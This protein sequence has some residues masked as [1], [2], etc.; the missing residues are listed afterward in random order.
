MLINDDKF[1]SVTSMNINEKVLG[2]RFNR[3]RFFVNILAL[4]HILCEIIRK[5]LLV[6]PA[7]FKYGLHYLQVK[8]FVLTCSQKRHHLYAFGFG[9]KKKKSIKCH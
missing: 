7:P 3:K 5:A 9:K 1:P 8:T 4:F 2:L 6:W